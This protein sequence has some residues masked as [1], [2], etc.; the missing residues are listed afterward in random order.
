MSEAARRLAFIA[1]GLVAAALAGVLALEIRASRTQQGTPLAAAA[2]RPPAEAAPALP[3]AT[4]MH[5]DWTAIL[6]ARPLFTP[7]R[8]PA[9][10]SQTAPAQPGGLPRLAGILVSPSGRQAIFAGPKDGK[11]IVTRE[12][13][14]IADQLVQSIRPG[15]VTVLG[16]A[17]ARVLHPA[18]DNTK[19]QATPNAAQ[20]AKPSILDLLRNGPPPGIGIPGLPPPPAAHP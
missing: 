17:G 20:P 13:D 1:I 7:S 16:P 6:L 12:G 3:T 4:N 10:A 5:P 11:P 8:R 18:F 15:E 9:P 14:R 2:E 19:T